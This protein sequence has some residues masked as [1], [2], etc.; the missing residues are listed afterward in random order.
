MRWALCFNV[1]WT[2]WQERY[3]RE[4]KTTKGMYR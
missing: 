3:L 1:I 4:E 2:V